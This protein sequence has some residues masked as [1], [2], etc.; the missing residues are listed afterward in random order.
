MH[1][2]PPKGPDGVPGRQYKG[3]EGAGVNKGRKEGEK[4][5]AAERRMKR[6]RGERLAL[7]I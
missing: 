5:E 7:T 3:G 4:C 6:K 1:F 2:T